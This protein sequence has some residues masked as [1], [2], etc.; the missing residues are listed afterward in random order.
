MQCATFRVNMH[1]DLYQLVSCTC[2]H[3]YEQR[4]I[5]TDPINVNMDTFFGSH[6]QCI[7]YSSS[8]RTPCS[9][10]HLELVNMPLAQQLP[11]NLHR[12]HTCV[13]TYE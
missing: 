11:A 8:Y 2:M 12:A 3:T 10:L 13:A 5:F 7:Y 1:D 6:I 4:R 9:V